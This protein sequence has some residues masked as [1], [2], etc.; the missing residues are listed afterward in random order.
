MSRTNAVGQL[1]FPGGHR[2][3]KVKEVQ[4]QEVF[5]TES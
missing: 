2:L 5:S 4:L 1:G 3:K